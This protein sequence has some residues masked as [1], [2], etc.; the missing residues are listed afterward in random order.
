MD[1][2]QCSLLTAERFA[3]YGS[4][5]EKPMR[6]GDVERDYLS[7]WGGLYDLDFEGTAS[8]GILSIKRRPF[9]VNQLE[10]HMKAV[11]IFVPV[12]GTSI[13]P[14]A[15]PED[16]TKCEAF[17]VDG[18]AGIVINKGVWHF[19][20]FPVTE[21]MEF[22]LTVRKE[23]ADDLEIRDIPGRRIIM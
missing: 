16:I 7:W 19:P 18:T 2:V 21:R 6:E 15:G 1:I 3:P 10:R 13:M 9:I 11:E 14:F 23:T 12:H 4:L 17:I 5:I 22:V 20:P 8:L